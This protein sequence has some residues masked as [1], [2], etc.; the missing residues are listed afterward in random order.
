MSLNITLYPLLNAG[1]T[2]EDIK[3]VLSC[4]VFLL[5]LILYAPVNNFSVMLGWVFLS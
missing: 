4:F 1:S 3:N 2:Q 5:G